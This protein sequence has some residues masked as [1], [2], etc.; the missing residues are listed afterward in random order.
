MTGDRLALTLAALSGCAHAPR[1][2]EAPVPAAEVWARFQAG[3]P[4][5]P[6]LLGGFRTLRGQH[7]VTVDAETG[8][9]G[10][11]RRTLRA[12]IAVERP[13][14]FR[15]R[16]LGPAGITLF[17]ILYVDGNVDVIAAARRP[18]DGRFSA[19]LDSIAGDLAATYDL[20]PYLPFQNGRAFQLNGDVITIA[21]PK[22]V[23][24]LDDFRGDGGRAAPRHIEIDNRSSGYHVSIDAHDSV[25]DEP[26]D[27]ALFRK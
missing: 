2:P 19:L 9:G 22:R 17:D 7:H 16:A 8:G 4:G 21:E 3:P 1:A 14:R 18:E 10:R 13:D 26:L 25:L 11:E 12:V 5:H 23:V 27:P 20:A 15:L 6:R 24:H